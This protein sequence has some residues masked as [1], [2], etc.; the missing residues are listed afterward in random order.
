MPEDVAERRQRVKMYM[1]MCQSVDQCERSRPCSSRAANARCA[2]SIAEQRFALNDV[3]DVVRPMALL[4]GTLLGMHWLLS[5]E[6]AS[7]WISW[8]GAAAIV[9]MI[10]FA[11]NGLIEV[12]GD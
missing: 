9:V 2:S 7:R 12:F 1:P 8:A 5:R 4:V 6:F 3:V 10:F 11:L